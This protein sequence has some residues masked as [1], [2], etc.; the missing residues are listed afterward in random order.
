[1]KSLRF[2]P[3]LF[4]HRSA[5]A[6][7]IVGRFGQFTIKTVQGFQVVVAFLQFQFIDGIE[8]RKVFVST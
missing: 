5:E 2:R 6:S 8:G 7:M 3:A 4:W 1:L